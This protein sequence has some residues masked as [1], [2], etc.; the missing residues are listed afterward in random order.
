M[1]M[2]I[3]INN[4]SSKC[5]AFH[6]KGRRRFRKYQKNLKKINRE[7]LIKALQNKNSV[8]MVVAM[9]H[10]VRIYYAHDKKEDIRV[11]FRSACRL[12]RCKNF[13]KPRRGVLVNLYHYLEF[14]TDSEPVLMLFPYDLCVQLNEKEA[15]NAKK[16]EKYL[17][18]IQF[19]IE[20]K[21][22]FAS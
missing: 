17:T 10:Y 21:N 12:L 20:R 9:D 16:L 3:K 1:A 8:I 19:G 4:K 13:Y 22:A 2:P 15:K 7:R 14:K 11:T 6:S 5:R 18:G